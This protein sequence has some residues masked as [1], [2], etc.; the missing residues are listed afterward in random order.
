MKLR[1]SFTVGAIAWCMFGQVGVAQPQAAAPTGTAPGGTPTGADSPPSTSWMSPSPANSVPTPS[2]G[3]SNTIN[4]SPGNPYSG[5]RGADTQSMSAQPGQT[6]SMERQRLNALNRQSDQRQ[7]VGSSDRQQ[8]LNSPQGTSGV[9]PV[10]PQFAQPGVALPLKP[11]S[12]AR[13]VPGGSI[14]GGNVVVDRGFVVNDLRRQGMLVDDWRVVDQNGRWWFWTP[15]N[16][17]LYYS[18]DRWVEYPT[19]NRGSFAGLQS[20]PVPSGFAAEDWRLVSHEGRWWFW[21][22]N[23]TWMYFRNGRWN[24]F[25]PGGIVSTRSEPESRYGAG[26]RGKRVQ[27]VT[28]NAAPVPARDAPDQTTNA[29]QA[30]DEAGMNVDAQH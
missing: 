11:T 2:S 29:I 12:A 9:V 24:D 28:P 17:W 10:A 6:G 27:S 4:N 16:R 5:S 20:A 19:E 21:T 30:P 7:T 25:P 22:P 8:Q 3:R 14:H 26:Y 23:E 1:L 15:E 18:A 13:V